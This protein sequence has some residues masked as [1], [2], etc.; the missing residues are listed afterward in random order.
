[1]IASRQL[2]TFTVTINYALSLAEMIAAGQNDEVSPHVTT[3]YF[4]VQ[5][6]GT[7]NERV[8]LI[9]FN[10]VVDSDEAIF[11]IEQMGLVPARIEHLLSWSAAHWDFMPEYMIL[12]L[13]SVCVSPD[14]IPC[15]SLLWRDKKL[16]AL[17]LTAYG[18][19]W[20]PCCR[21]LAVRK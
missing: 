10:F 8:V 18:N 9:P 17:G 3:K 7:F 14:G 2:Q 16:R 15:I 5:G 13:G 19:L 21:F 4:S 11:E 6:N 12:C 20:Y 1:M